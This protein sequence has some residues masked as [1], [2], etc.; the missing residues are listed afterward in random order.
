MDFLDPIRVLSVGSHPVQVLSIRSNPVRVLTMRSDAIR[1]DPG[2]V[3]AHVWRGNCNIIFVLF[4]NDFFPCMY[5][6][7]KLYLQ[8]CLFFF[9][10][11]TV[12]LLRQKVIWKPRKEVSLMI[13]TLSS[14]II[15]FLYLFIIGIT[16]HSIHSEPCF[17]PCFRQSNMLQLKQ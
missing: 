4:K 17:Q 2:F 5:C 16:N 3:N 6:A 14:V 11:L 15:I 8:L 12:S 13:N 1:S 7:P 10:F 9:S